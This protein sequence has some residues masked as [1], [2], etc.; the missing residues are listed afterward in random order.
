MVYTL[1]I[2]YKASLTRNMY[3]FE[4]CFYDQL[5]LYKFFAQLCIQN[6]QN[7]MSWT[8]VGAPSLYSCG[9]LVSHFNWA[10]Y[11]GIMSTM[12]V[13]YNYIELY[14]KQHKAQIHQE[15]KIESII[16]VSMV[17][18]QKGHQLT[19]MQNKVHNKFVKVTG[20]FSRNMFYHTLQRLQTVMCMW[21]TQI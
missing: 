19:H 3:L 4:E 1:N 8:L 6:P 2:M 15:L 9:S 18:N 13:F 5:L 21:T 14:N 17:N 11:C 10:T 20:H 7:Y 16:L 12:S